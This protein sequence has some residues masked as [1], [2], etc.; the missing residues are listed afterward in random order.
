MPGLRGTGGPA[1]PGTRRP[2]GRFG[3][4]PWG[5]GATLVST[6]PVLYG[7]DVGTVNGYS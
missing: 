1:A 6:T 2:F 4:G 5:H 3:A 7:P